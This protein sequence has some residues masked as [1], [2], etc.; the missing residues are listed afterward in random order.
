M[1][2]EGPLRE[3]SIH[4]V[5]QLLDLSRE[6]GML[7]VSSRVR[8]N[9]GSVYFEQGAIIHARIDSN[10]HPLGAVLLKAGKVTEADLQRAGGMQQRGDKRRLG[11]ILVAIGSLSRRDLDRQVRLQI[12][13]V[14]FEIMSWREGYFAFREGP[15]TDIAAEATVRIPT[16]LLLL[17]AT[18]RIEEWSRI[19]SRVPHAGI[20][21]VLAAANAEGG[22]L[23]L[24]AAEWELLAVVDGERDLRAIGELLSRSEFD[25]AR[26]AFGLESAGLIQLVDRSDAAGWTGDTESDLESLLE[27]AV[28][29]LEAGDADGAE[30]WAKAARARFP[31]EPMPLVVG[32]R[33][34]LLAGR[35]VEAEQEVRK[36][37]RLDPLIMDAHRLLGDA[38]VRQ[39]RLTEAVDWWNR[40]LTLAAHSGEHADEAR[41]VQDAVR[42]AG[43]LTDFL[44]V[45]RD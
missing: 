43:S 7:T 17:E 32:G 35:P 18:R 19:A 38:L 8:Q 14:V 13:E 5:F 37:L 44:E 29:A 20:V 15:L 12:E 36:A 27:R 39:G 4:D 16:G 40:W 21:P 22:R 9:R 45:W 6:T 1:T 2:I 10:P 23:E 3:L 42:A 41:L 26:T 33:A 30:H 31:N 11:E 34:Q 28:A 25:V 24:L